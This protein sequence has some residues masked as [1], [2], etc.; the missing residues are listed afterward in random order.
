MCPATSPEHA[1]LVN[2][3][4]A[5]AKEMRACVGDVLNAKPVSLSPLPDNR[6]NTTPEL[7]ILFITS[8]QQ[9]S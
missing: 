1:E 9:C 4:K 2:K 6:V 5:N 7:L 8:E 3:E